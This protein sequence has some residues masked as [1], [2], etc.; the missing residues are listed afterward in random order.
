MRVT[1]VD[2]SDE[3]A[4]IITADGVAW[5]KQME[6]DDEPYECPG[7]HALSLARTA[8]TSAVLFRASLPPAVVL[9]LAHQACL[10]SRVYDINTMTVIPQGEITLYAWV[11]DDGEAPHACGLLDVAETTVM[12]TEG[13]EHVDLILAGLLDDGMSLVTSRDHDLPPCG[14]FTVELGDGLII[15]WRGSARSRSPWYAGHTDPRLE[16]WRHTAESE[17]MIELAVGSAVVPGLAE[18]ASGGP[19]E[20]PDARDDGHGIG[21]YLDAAINA[22]QVVGARVKVLDATGN[23]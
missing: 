8:L 15:V 16:H 23:Q 13:G 17:G 14:R 21:P 10:P 20:R 12:P 18:G 11:T 3:V 4:R 1:G 2:I 19:D 9:V 5:I 22:G 6:A 7:C